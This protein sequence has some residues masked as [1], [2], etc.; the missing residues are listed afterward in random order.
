MST[1]LERRLADIE[2]IE[3]I[4]ALK[5]RYWR[6]CDNKDPDGFRSC[7]IAH[8]ADM[9]YGAMGKHDDVGPILQIFVDVALRKVD[10][11]YNVLDMHHGFMPE[12]TMVSPTQATGRWTLL[13]RQV[14]LE[15]GTDT[16]MT[17]EYD[18]GYVIEDGVWKMSKC[19]F[20]PMWT[21]TRPLTDA[22]TVMQMLG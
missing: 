13:F 10:G 12:I 1:D 11:R 8:G 19:H 20:R 21:V 7:F 14:N 16:S 17:G 5:H 4:K 3:A 18:D 22:D 15:A 2:A 9:D 6:S